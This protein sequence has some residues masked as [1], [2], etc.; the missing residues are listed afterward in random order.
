MVTMNLKESDV[1]SFVSGD[2]TL[3]GQGNGR[4]HYRAAMLLREL[5]LR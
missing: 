2:R 4:C 1:S 3:I 5:Y